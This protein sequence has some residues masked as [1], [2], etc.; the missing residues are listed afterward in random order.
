MG[1]AINAQAVAFITLS[2]VQITSSYGVAEVVAEH[3][4]HRKNI[5]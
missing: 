3:Y 2:R 1:K 4:P 5:E